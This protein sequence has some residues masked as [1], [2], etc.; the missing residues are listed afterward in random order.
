[1]SGNLSGVG[2]KLDR[3]GYAKLPDVILLRSPDVRPPRWSIL[4]L[5]GFA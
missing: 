1:M 3:E 4:R 5:E 2:A